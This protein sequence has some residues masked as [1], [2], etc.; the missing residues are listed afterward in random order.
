M[1][2]YALELEDGCW[3]IGKS[4]NLENRLNSHHNGGGAAWTKLHKP[5]RTACAREGDCEKEM[6][7]Y[8]VAKYGLDKVR[9]YHRTQTA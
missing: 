6:Y 1:K 4:A 3:Y 7:E 9:G 5:I 8:A 2:T